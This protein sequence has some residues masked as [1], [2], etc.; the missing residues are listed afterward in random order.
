MDTDQLEE[1]RL[2]TLCRVRG[3]AEESA[4]VSGSPW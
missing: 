1:L 2:L 3:Y 4:A